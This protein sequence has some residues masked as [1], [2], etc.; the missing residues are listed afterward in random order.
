MSNIISHSLR[1]NK[2]K[3]QKLY[4]IFN[5]P[6]EDGPTQKLFF[7]LMLLKQQIVSHHN[8]VYVNPKAKGRDKPNFLHSSTFHKGMGYILH[9][10]TTHWTL[11]FQINL[12]YQV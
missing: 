12:L 9:F 4:A 10:H 3:S 8:L 7:L 6:M 11:G 2:R 5:N 1:K